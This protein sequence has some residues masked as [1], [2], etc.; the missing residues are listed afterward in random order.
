VEPIIGGIT[1]IDL[2]VVGGVALV[3]PTASRV[4]WR[5]WLLVAAATALACAVDRGSVPALALG[6][7]WPVLATASLGAEIRAWRSWSPD[8][9]AQLLAG[10]YGLVAAGGMLL[11]LAERMPFGIGE[12]IVEL[13]AVHFTY[14]AI[15]GLALAGRAL[16]TA[17][18]RTRGLAWAAVLVTAGAPPM[19][20]TGFVT[21]SA[22]AQV[23]G[24]V[25]MAT[26]VWLTGGL[27]LHRAVR[28]PGDGP[29]RA[30]LG[31]SG[32][33]VIAP[34]VLAV[35]WAL[36]QHADVPALSINDMIR[37]HGAGNSLGFIGAGLLA[38]W[39]DVRAAVGERHAVGMAAPAR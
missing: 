2:A 37:T 6:T 16:A 20:A 1:W 29:V 27:Q 9:G 25:A 14:A 33:A 13:T 22:V 12:P 17:G 31:I 28:G 34:M 11:S 24:A 15:G 39:L 5:W 30:L 10:A 32:V 26:G 7:G 36:A 23:G 8:G 4:R 38:R 21:E 19:V 35:S 3:A 18:D